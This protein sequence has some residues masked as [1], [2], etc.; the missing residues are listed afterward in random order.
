M[1]SSRRALLASVGSGTVL[2]SGCSRFSSTRSREPPEPDEPPES[3]VDELPDPS[4]HVHGANGEWSSFGCNAANTRTVADGKAPVDGGSERWRVEAS[5][6]ARQ[7]LVAAGGRVYLP[8]GSELSVFDADDGTELWSVE[9][10]WEPPLV[11]EDVVYVSSI[12]GVHALEAE[13]GDELWKR[14]VD[15]PG[16][17]TAPAIVGGRNLIC[18]FGER[19]VALDPEDG[20][21]RWHR[22]VF[23]QVLDHAATLGQ[24]WIVVATE[25]GM[26]YTLAGNGVAYNR[27]Q[28]PEPP[29]APPS[30]DGETIYVNCRDGNTYAL[31][32]ENESMTKF[33]WTVETG[34]ARGGI[35]VVDDIVLT[36]G[37][38]TLR[39]IDAES[40]LRYWDHEIGDWDHTA[41]AYGRET[42]FVGGDR[43]W[44]LDLAP[45]GNPADGPAIRFEREFAGEIVGPGP[46]LDDG[47][48]Y[49]VAQVEDEELVLLALE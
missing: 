30:T 31:S 48:L 7:G 1:T 26:V 32:D 42:V 36:A 39:A 15:V 25:A 6:M 46:V 47:A 38:R 33:D 22:D 4:R 18:A 43:L 40:G 10:V 12:D 21:V 27:W 19:V 44:A 9:N 20:S 35:A 8:D 34:W 45:E 24:R 29:T 2:L 13:T 49:V 3:G 37:G 5:P 16:N 23:G 11:W 41:P 28:L 17:A 14:T